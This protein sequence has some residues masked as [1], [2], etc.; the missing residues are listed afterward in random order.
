MT[1]PQARSI[2]RRR[3]APDFS[4][5]RG[6]HVWSPVDDF[7]GDFCNAYTL[8]LTEEHEFVRIVRH[9]L[10]KLE[11]PVLRQQLKGWLA[12][13]TT[14]GIQ[15]TKAHQVLER[16]GLRHRTL[17][18]F[19][20]FLNFRIVVRIIGLRLMLFVVA[21][22]EHFNTMLGEMFL[23]RR[24]AFRDS[25]ESMS[26]LLRWHFAEEIEH[27]A[28]IHDVATALRMGYVARVFTGALAFVFYAANLFVVAWI[29]AIQR[30]GLF[31]LGTHRSA[32]RF[33]FVEERFVQLFFAYARSYMR[34]DFHPLNRQIDEL[35]APIL[36]QLDAPA[37]GPQ[38]SPVA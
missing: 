23:R 11:D 4:A 8:L 18:R 22:L 27:R 5:A 3:V 32:F 26:L 24:E 1:S 31:R 15:H 16:Q 20:H 38:P 30:G 12:Q 35:A 29:F 19:L 9:A 7:S 34:L 33:L 36:A 13:E 28:V 21:G 14:H 2:A 10:S 17:L 6:E 37:V 25:D